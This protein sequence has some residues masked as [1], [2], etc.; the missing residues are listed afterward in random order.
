M[1][2]KHR[3]RGKTKTTERD[4]EKFVREEKW[5]LYGTQLAVTEDISLGKGRIT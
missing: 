4:K 5:E 1:Y 2:I 3:N